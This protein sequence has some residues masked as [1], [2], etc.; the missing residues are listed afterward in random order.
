MSAL[1][2]LYFRVFILIVQLFMKIPALKVPAPTQSEPPFK[3]AQLVVLVL[4]IVLTVAAAKRSR[5][6]QPNPA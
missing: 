6:P 2:A 3:V 5:N 4:F 1:V